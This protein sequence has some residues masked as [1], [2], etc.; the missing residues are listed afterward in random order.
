MPALFAAEDSKSGE[1]PSEEI[2]RKLA[3]MMP[4]QTFKRGEKQISKGGVAPEGTTVT[5]GVMPAST[6]RAIFIVHGRNDE[7]KETVARFLAQL[8]LKGE[9][10]PITC[11]WELGFKQPATGKAL[12]YW[13]E[14][15]A[16]RTMPI[17]R[18]LSPSAMRE[19]SSATPCAPST[20]RPGSRTS[21]R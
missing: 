16:G 13:R 14:L 20:S 7:L 15:C 11:D 17:R 10:F 2:I 12:V 21:S 9:V 4:D 19:G 5:R 6:S 8:D 1:G 18:E 3:A